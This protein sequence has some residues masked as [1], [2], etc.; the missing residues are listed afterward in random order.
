MKGKNSKPYPSVRWKTAEGEI[1]LPKTTHKRRNIYQ[2]KD[3]YEIVLFPVVSTDAGCP[4]R[5]LSK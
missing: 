2:D 4:A 1:K 5:F 3:Q